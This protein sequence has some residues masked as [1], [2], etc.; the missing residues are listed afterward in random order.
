MRDSGWELV[1]GMLLGLVL[2]ASGAYALVQPDLC[3]VCRCGGGASQCQAVIEP[4][5][6]EIACG[7]ITNTTCSFEVV[8]SSCASVAA[9]NLVGAPTLDTT[10]LTAATLALTVLGIVGLRRAARRQRG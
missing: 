6:C 2:L 7:E 9:C 4:F 3:C 8:N 10:G 1:I 5:A